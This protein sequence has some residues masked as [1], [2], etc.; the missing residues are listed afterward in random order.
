MSNNLSHWKLVGGFSQK[1][2]AYLAV[3]IDPM[4]TNLPPEL[5][6]KVL[7]MEREINSAVDRAFDYAW[8]CYRKFDNPWIVDDSVPDAELLKLTAPDI[9]EV[10]GTMQLFLPTI[11]LRQNVGNAFSDPANYKVDSR[12]IWAEHGGTETLIDS[13]LD[14]WFKANDFEPAFDFIKRRLNY[15]PHA[16]KQETEN[17]VPQESS[18]ILA[19]AFN[20]QLENLKDTY[21]DLAELLKIDSDV[22]KLERIGNWTRIILLDRREDG[23]SFL[24][25]EDIS[26]L[27]ATGIGHVLDEQQANKEWQA[28]SLNERWVAFGIHVFCRIV[29]G[30]TTTEE[31]PFYL[32][33]L[34]SEMAGVLSSGGIEQTRDNSVVDNARLAA[35]ARHS[36]PGGSREKRRQIITAWASGKYSSRD[37]C[38]E[39]ECA[40]L[41]MSFSTARKA[42]RGTPEPS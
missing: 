19:E 36:M 3:G 31:E 22:S 6:A 16:P 7:L 25:E 15:A 34:A 38:A 2:A 5:S 10:S 27:Q 41:G 21:W 33:R 20:T 24:S 37:I 39:Q 26:L 14:N 42:L 11:E 29:A 18:D 13:E 8:S 40:A 17:I 23:E 32:F 1:E 9:W 35:D 12:S 30:G 4:V 28:A